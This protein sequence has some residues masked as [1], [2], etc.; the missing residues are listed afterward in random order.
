MNCMTD[1]TYT[2][3][4]KLIKSV[5]GIAGVTAITGIATGKDDEHPGNG[6][7]TEGSHSEQGHEFDDL[8]QDYEYDLDITSRE[9]YD[10]VVEINVEVEKTH[11]D[12]PKDTE[13]REFAYEVP[14]DDGVVKGGEIHTVDEGELGVQRNHHPIPPD[15]DDIIEEWGYWVEPDGGCDDH[16]G[17]THAYFGITFELTEGADGIAGVTL[18]SAVG[19]LVGSIAPG[20]GTI[21]GTIAGF[22]VGMLNY[23][24]SDTSYTI[25][26]NEW[27]QSLVVTDQAMHT[28][29]GANS[30]DETN[31]SNQT[32]FS[33]S[34]GHP[35]RN[36]G[37][38]F[39]NHPDA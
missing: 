13:V 31:K 28:V 33:V 14:Q 22:T 3:R 23:L 27:D 4:R 29:A 7:E 19:A 6:R 8:E 30:Y 21:A 20:A 11:V 34:P 1:E 36:A 35:I 12:D 10:D 15:A 5:G 25:S 38:T 39:R 26:V 17:Y 18:T 24:T 16:D 37:L 32:R 2:G 9:E